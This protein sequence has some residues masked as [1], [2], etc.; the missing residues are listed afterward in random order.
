M[1]RVNTTTLKVRE[2]ASTESSVLGLVPIDDELIVTEELEGWLISR[3]ASDT[4][5]PNS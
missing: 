1:A 3:K 2:D 4:Y 5:L